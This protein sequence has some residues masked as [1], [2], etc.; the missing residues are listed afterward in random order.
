MAGT[1]TRF[2]SGIGGDPESEIEHWPFSE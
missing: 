2:C 1:E